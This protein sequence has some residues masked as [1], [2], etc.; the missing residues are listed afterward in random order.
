MQASNVHH[1]C[2]LIW[3]GARSCLAA[4]LLASVGAEA[5]T[6]SP[7]LEHVRWPLLDMVMVPDSSGVWFLVAPTPATRQWESGSHLVDLRIEPVLVLQWVTLARRLTPAGIRL[8]PKLRGTR[9]PQFLLLGRNR[10]KASPEKTFYLVASD[11]TRRTQ[12]KTFAS[13]AQVDSLLTA[14]ERTARAGQAT[15]DPAAEPEPDTPVSV[16]FQPRPAYPGE[17]ASKRRIGRVW[18]QYVVGADGRA[19]PGSFRPLLTDDSLF[20]H[21]AIR[22]L[23]RGRYKPAYANGQPVPQ[24]VFQAIIFRVR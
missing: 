24:R 15:F 11:S 8:T 5:Q 2:S 1:G 14:L 6:I 9:G 13:S 10:A 18:M 22:A 23:L 4:V 19:Q 17:L 12:W 7:Q 20:T 16:V 3:A 21:A